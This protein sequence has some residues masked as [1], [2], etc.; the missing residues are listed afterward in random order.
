LATLITLAQVKEIRG[1]TTTTDDTL[2]TNLINRVDKAVR[3][4]C[5]RDFES[6]SYTDYYDGN[7][8]TELM[9]KQF[10]VTA[11]TS[12]KRVDKDK[13]TVLYTWAVADYDVIL[14][15]GLLRLRSG[16]FT[17]GIANIEVKYTA[18]Y[19]T[20]PE[21]LAQACI[22]FV[23]WLYEDRAR[24]RVGII[25]RVMKDGSTLRYTQYLPI[26]ISSVL[27]RYRKFGT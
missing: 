18:G 3:L 22:S 6:L 2:L 4:I 8:N 13:T 5:S 17:P 21:D 23:G 16:T 20:I 25:S 10:P 24:E 15:I 19:I 1:I 9:L 12:V 26:E 14:D 7:G 11:I 27:S